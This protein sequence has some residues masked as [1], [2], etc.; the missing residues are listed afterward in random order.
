MTI[1]L[2]LSDR[3]SDLI[4]HYADMHGMTVSEVVRQSVISRIED[5]FDLAAYDQALAAYHAD[6]VTYSHAE[7]RKMLELDA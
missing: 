5:E 1:S 6:P 4:R 3:D 2:R 7:V